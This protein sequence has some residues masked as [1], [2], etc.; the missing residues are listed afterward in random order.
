[1]GLV[2]AIRTH[3]SRLVLLA[4]TLLLA[5]GAVEAFLRLTDRFPVPPHPV[6]PQNPSVYC[7]YEW[8]YGLRPD[9]ELELT[10]GARK[11]VLRSNR[12]GFRGARRL[13]E[14]D[15]RVRILVAGDSFVFG[16]G[17]EEH[18][19]FTDLIEKK[20]SGWRLDNIGMN[21]YGTDLTLRAVEQVGFLTEPDAVL[22][23][24]YSDAFP[25]VMPHFVGLGY[26]VPRF[27]LSGGEL[28]SVPYPQW[29][30]W[31]AL[32]T[33]QLIRRAWWRWRES[34]WKIN[35]AVLERFFAH[36]EGRGFRPAV[37]FF[38]GFWPDTGVDRERR[39]FVTELCDRSDVPLLDVSGVRDLG[40][41]RAFIGIHWN[42]RGHAWVAERVGGFLESVL[43]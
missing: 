42:A 41:K 35:A 12:H 43:E 27:E 16:W 30:P 4:L 20:H 2:A 23:C 33:R 5:T 11:F 29:Y 25:R 19:R 32:R 6:V 38:A 28:H 17:V 31:D 9:A 39:R 21:G 36:A 3:R 18:E 40:R 34:E 14:E 24:I 10:H 37:L 1:M 7:P 22:F 8:G 13:D 26:E 15:D